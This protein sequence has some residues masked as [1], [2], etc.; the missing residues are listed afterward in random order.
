[1]AINFEAL[2]THLLASGDILLQNW[3]P[4]G[5]K[6]GREFM[7]GNLSGEPGESLSINL[8]TG[9]WSDF[10]TGETGG[11]LISLYAAKHGISQG[12]AA[13]HL[14]PEYVGHVAPV[15]SVNIAGPKTDPWIRPPLTVI[16]P[17]RFEHRVLGPAS[18]Y[19]VYRDEIGPMFVVA[20]YDQ[21]EGRKQ[22]IPWVWSSSKWLA[23]WPAAPR[24]LYGLDR[25]AKMPARP[26]LLVEGEKAAEA[27]QDLFPTRPCM[28]W[29]SGTSGV[30]SADWTPLK[31]R[32]VD[33]W[34]DADTPGRHAAAQIAGILIGLQ[35]TVRVVDTQDKPS[36]WDLADA[37]AEGLTSADI[38]AYARKNIAAVLPPKPVRKT[39][40]LAESAVVKTDP[41]VLI[42]NNSIPSMI[43]RWGTMGLALRSNGSPYPDQANIMLAVQQKSGYTPSF[44][45]FA[46]RPM[47]GDQEL[48]D[49]AVLKITQW[50][51]TEV[52][53]RNASTRIVNDALMCEANSHA[54]NPLTDWLGSLTWDGSERLTDLMSEGF[55]ADA[56]EYT[57][58]VG[59]CFLIGLV[60]RAMRPGCKLDS[61]PVFEGSQGAGKSTALAVLGGKWFA[62]IHESIGSK[63]FYLS[64]AGKWLVE[65]A[66]LHA[67][68]RVEVERIKGIITTSTDRFRSPYERY[69]RD[70]PR[71]CAFAGTT[72]LDD[73]NADE[74]GARRFWPIKCKSLDLDWLRE[75]REQLFA[76]AVHRFNSGED[77]WVIPEGE[78]NIEREARR[79]TD[80]WE[81]QLR[82]YIDSRDEIAIASVLTDILEIEPGKQDMVAQKRVTRILRAN[83]FAAVQD[84]SGPSVVRR[85]VRSKSWRSEHQPEHK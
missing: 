21:P 44:D 20:R 11:D 5:K 71:Q 22:I 47:L 46:G 9:K 33:I 7:V 84:R 14:G 66:E 24:P 43:N 31:G 28:T 75:H 12:D 30:Q 37:L 40:E 42:H 45:L 70:H 68:R 77:W 76:E 74:T 73:W 83:G 69:S 51:Q 80:P 65:I 59:R 60:A 38:V 72:N 35:C 61:M 63:D 81:A 54:Y 27:A 3:F 10:A 13:R 15:Q 39:P 1:V 6:Q 19:W 49:S 29:P 4:A 78:A 17:V 36:G 32:S 53:M 50:L 57:R 26:V 34:P 56:N 16:D 82:T 67:F 64:I 25:L 52:G 48:S 41:G 62:E 55:G 2:A 23:K 85:W 58:A 8:K 18:D 79:E